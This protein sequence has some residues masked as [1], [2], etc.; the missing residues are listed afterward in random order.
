[1]ETSTKQAVSALPDAKGANITLKVV[2]VNN[3]SGNMNL[4]YMTD[5]YLHFYSYLFIKGCGHNCILVT[6][7]RKQIK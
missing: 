3:M 1:V 6:E 5:V 7:D 4:L 2:F